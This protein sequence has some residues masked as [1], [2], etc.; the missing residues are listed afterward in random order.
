MAIQ[1]GKYEVYVGPPEEVNLEVP[2]DVLCISGNQ[3]TSRCVAAIR[4]ELNSRADLRF[5]E[6]GKSRAEAILLL[7]EV[8]GFGGNFNVDSGSFY[9]GHTPLPAGVEVHLVENLDSTDRDLAIRLSQQTPARWAHIAAEPWTAPGEIV[10]FFDPLLVD[11]LR[12]PL[13]AVWETDDG[14]ERWYFL[15]PGCDWG[16]VL[17]WLVIA[18]IPRYIPDA[19]YRTRPSEAITEAFMT[20]DELELASQLAEFERTTEERR[21]DLTKALSTAQQKASGVRNPLL[22]GKGH[23]LKK[24]VKSILEECDFEVEDLDDS[25]GEGMSADLVAR[26]N[27][28]YWLVE[29]TSSSGPPSETEW[30]KLGGHLKIWP[31]LRDE[32]LSGGVLIINN[33]HRQQPGKRP[34]PYVRQAFLEALDAPVITTTQI[35][36]WWRDQDC[37]ALQAAVTGSPSVY[38]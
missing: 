10:G 17:D 33:H 3:D 1:P 8:P 13:C 19:V 30:T 16:P 23:T 34:T 18:A 7:V 11:D 21:T 14:S 12:E 29:V 28:R 27:N 5:R 15:P 31:T 36:R 25:L 2:D 20:S 37:A 26:L 38:H 4:P 24:A 22:F 35:V 32:K 6:G 9:L